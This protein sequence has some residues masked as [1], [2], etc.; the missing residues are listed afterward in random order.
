LLIKLGREIEFGTTGLAVLEGTRTEPK[1]EDLTD[2][3]AVEL[4][5]TVEPL[6]EVWI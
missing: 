1:V 2:G 5:K 3:A 4:D 6:D